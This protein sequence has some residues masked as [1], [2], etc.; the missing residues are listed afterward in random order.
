MKKNA[1]KLA[2]LPKVQKGR[3]YYFS[4]RPELKDQIVKIGGAFVESGQVQVITAGTKQLKSSLLV[5][6]EDDN[7]AKMAAC[8]VADELGLD[9]KG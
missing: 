4:N 2:G 1:I 7:L 3:I 6:A 9:L 8:I 5:E